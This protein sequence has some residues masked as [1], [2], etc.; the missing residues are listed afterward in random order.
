MSGV[1]QVDEAV[2]RPRVHGQRLL[3]LLEDTARSIAYHLSSATDRE[4]APQQDPWESFPQPLVYIPPEDQDF[5]NGRRMVA[6]K[7]FFRSLKKI[8]AGT[9]A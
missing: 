5:P 9:S 3:D 8:L 6:P 1:C 7:T 4:Q 2:I